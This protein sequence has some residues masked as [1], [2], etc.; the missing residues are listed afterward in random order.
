MGTN[1]MTSDWQ[2]IA[3]APKEKN[4]SILLWNGSVS[5]AEADDCGGWYGMCN[6]DYAWENEL[7]LVHVYNPTH[8]MPLPG[9]PDS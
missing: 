1:L 2:P 5:V 3:T 7:Y 8:W 4:V 9:K 6:G